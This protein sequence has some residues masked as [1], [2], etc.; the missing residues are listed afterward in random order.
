M[1]LYLAVF[2]DGNDVAG[3]DLGAYADFNA[4]RDYVGRELESGAPGSRF[5][6][7]MLH[8]DCEGEWTVPDC[9]HLIA[10]I[11]TIAAEMKTRPAVA[12]PSDWQEA[13]AHV[14]ALEPRSAFE[15]FLEVDGEFLLE[16]LGELAEAARSLSQPILFQ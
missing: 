14:L 3:L 16:R 13:V 11:R 7:F 12:F 9:V 1:S 5:P 2:L 4:L 6:T 10:E 8:S 15:S